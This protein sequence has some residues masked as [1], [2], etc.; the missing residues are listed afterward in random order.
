MELELGWM[1]GV[2]HAYD[3]IGDYWEFEDGTNRFWFRKNIPILLYVDNYK[4]Y[5]S[6]GIVGTKITYAKIRT[7]L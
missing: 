1:E 6:T 4:W 5:D 2:G 3:P 7:R